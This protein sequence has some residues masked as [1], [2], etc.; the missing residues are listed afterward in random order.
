MIINRALIVLGLLFGIEASCGAAT[1]FVRP[2]VYTNMNK[3]TAMPNPE[4]GVYGAQNGTDYA[5]A[6]NGLT[7]I[8][9]GP[10]G[11]SSNDTLY[12]CGTHIYSI[13]LWIGNCNAQAA[14]LIRSSYVT[15]RGDWP[16]DPGTLFGGAVDLYHQTNAFSG[17]DANGVYWERSAVSPVFY[18]QNINGTTNIIRLK[19]RNTTTWTD[20][21]GGA[22]SLNGTN[23]IQLPDGSL[24]TTNNLARWSGGWA[25][26]LNNQSNIIFQSCHFVAANP[27]GDGGYG[28]IRHTIPPFPYTTAANTI[29]FTSCS[30]FDSDEFYL[31]PGENNFSFLSCEVARTPTVVYSLFNNSPDNSCPQN[32]TVSN[33]WI[34]DIGTPEY[35]DVDN[36]AV[37]IQGG[38]YHLI[39]HNTFSNTG[40]AIVL[41]TGNANMRSNIISYNFI[42]NTQTNASGGSS[43]ISLGGNNTLALAGYRIGNQIFGN[44]IYNCAVG[45]GWSY[46]VGAGIGIENYALD[47]TPIYNNTIYGG[48]CGI[49]SMATIAGYP[50]N[51]SIVNNIIIRPAVDY[52]YIAGSAPPTNLTADYNLYYPAPALSGHSTFPAGTPHDAHSVFANPLFVSSNPVVATDFQLSGSSGAI[53]AGISVGLLQDFAGT[54][55]PAGVRPDIGAFECVSAAPSPPTDLHVVPG[56]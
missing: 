42:M 52:Y 22:Y 10:R 27:D 1:W 30:F 40:P 5:N 23:Y 2:G 56:P 51:A 16:G 15:I 36:N 53:Q 46:G 31:Y 34:H 44:I 38:N 7:S 14:D 49:V 8:V 28:A 47:Y 11:V 41:W 29:T 55:Y 39:T 37:G 6:W 24:P 35:N 50:V 43:G 18:I 4:A 17:P 26:D 54:P 12:V 33:C 25:F 48:N 21:L 45:T 3:T 32:I 9:W 19:Y 20:G 13:T